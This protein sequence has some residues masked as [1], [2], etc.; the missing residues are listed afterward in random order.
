M[1]NRIV[2]I[3]TILFTL[4]AILALNTVTTKTTPPPTNYPKQPNSI[5]MPGGYGFMLVVNGL[6][7]RWNP[8]QGVI[9]VHLS[10]VSK[11]SKWGIELRKAI[12]SVKKYSGLQIELRSNTNFIPQYHWY[13]DSSKPG[14]NI[15][16]W[17]GNKSQTNIF[18]N[19]PDNA[20]GIADFWADDRITGADPIT[21]AAIVINKPLAT[22]LS[23]IKLRAVFKHEL[24]HTLNLDHVYDFDSLMQPT[25]TDQTW[26]G[27]GD[28]AGL[29]AVGASNG[30]II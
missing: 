15:T 7:A 20:Y 2:I 27:P 11:K 28:I 10:G 6:P 19:R 12:A 8:C 22:T 23:N 13:E 25:L 14:R 29:R 1:K 4:G 5:I 30:C 17:V 3:I 18:V 9:K 26:W 16:V 21:H 24:A